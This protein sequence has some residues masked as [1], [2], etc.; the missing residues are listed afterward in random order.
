MSQANPMEDA[1]ETI[2]DIE[3]AAAAVSMALMTGRADLFM[4]DVQDVM[5]S[6][7]LSQSMFMLIAGMVAEFAHTCD[8]KDVDRAVMVVISNMVDGAKRIIEEGVVQRVGLPTTTEG[9]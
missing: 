3:L 6:Q 9:L 2:E 4:S 1:H 8:V 5:G 7:R